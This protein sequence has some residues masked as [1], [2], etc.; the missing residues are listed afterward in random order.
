MEAEEEEWKWNTETDIVDLRSSHATTH[1]AS[2][3][4]FA[5][6]SQWSVNLADMLAIIHSAILNQLCRAE[7]LPNYVGWGPPQDNL[8]VFWLRL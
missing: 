4:G 5:S 6:F 2:G 7:C 3:Q 8:I 1:E